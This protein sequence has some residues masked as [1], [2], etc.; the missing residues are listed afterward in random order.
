MTETAAHVESST[1]GPIH[2]CAIP[3]RW[4]DFDRFGHMSNSIYVEIAQEA[5]MRFAIDEF[6]P[7]GLEIPTVFVRRLDADYL[8]PVLTDTT[9][10]TVD[11]QVISIGHT[12]FT[13]RQ[14]L[15]D[16]H[17]KICCIIEV[18]QIAMD[19]HTSSPRPI[20]EREIS[21]LTRAE[22][23]KAISDGSN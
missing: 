19:L 4:T 22:E 23:T 8:A 16:R 6:V 20:S 18:V 2:S 17:G 7:R 5:R 14:K 3:V 12:S 15:K 11:T 9:A 1:P 10:V 13:S 21:V